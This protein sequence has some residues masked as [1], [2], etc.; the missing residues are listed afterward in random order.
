MKVTEKT[1]ERRASES[2]LP[3]TSATVI[4]RIRYLISNSRRTQA[5]FARQAGIDPTGLSK[6]LAGRQPISGRTLGRIAVSTGCNRDWLDEGVG[7]PF[8]RIS[9]VP[10]ITMLTSGVNAVTDPEV[11]RFNLVG[12]PVYDIDVTAGHT[13]LSTAFTSEH[14]I[15]SLY[16]PQ[17]N[18]NNPI[19]HVSGHSMDPMIP[20]NSW[21]SIR[22]I[23]PDAPIFWG[24]PY[25]VITEDYRMVKIVRRHPTDDSLV[26]LHSANPE[27]DDIDMPRRLIRM[28]FLVESAMTYDIFG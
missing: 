9:E 6:M 12:A 10:D 17:I 25:L 14:I 22:R 27:F 13:E 21:I 23:A 16:M 19:V 26:I 11:C 20:H 8:P 15:G 24:Q 1:L 28:L 5:Q 4:D 3:D 18:P 7:I 2:V